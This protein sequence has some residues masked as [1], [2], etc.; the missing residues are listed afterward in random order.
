MEQAAAACGVSAEQQ[1]Q[2]QMLSG[3]QSQTAVREESE[4]SDFSGPGPCAPVAS[5]FTSEDGGRPPR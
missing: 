2:A 5:E 1:Q 4:M 3:I